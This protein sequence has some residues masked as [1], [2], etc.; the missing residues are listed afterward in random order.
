MIQI[1]IVNFW[2]KI[3]LLYIQTTGHT[4]F[5]Q[6]YLNVLKVNSQVTEHKMFGVKVNCDTYI[7]V[8]LSVNIGPF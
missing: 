3:R 4:N 1:F 2:K 6:F 8:P 7:G 5:S